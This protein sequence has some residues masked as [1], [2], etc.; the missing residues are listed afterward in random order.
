MT[1]DGGRSYHG[2]DAKPTRAANGQMVEET[3]DYAF[4]DLRPCTGEGLPLILLNDNPADVLDGEFG[5]LCDCHSTD[6]RLMCRPVNSPFLY[7]FV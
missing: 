5:I 6:L 3:K 4:Y 1:R 2:V 7:L